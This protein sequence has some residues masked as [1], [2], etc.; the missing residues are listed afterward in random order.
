MGAINGIG[1]GQVV[2]VGMT[3]GIGQMFVHWT[4]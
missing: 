1:H 2:A 4:P 3:R